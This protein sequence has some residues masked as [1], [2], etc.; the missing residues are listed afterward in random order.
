MPGSV[1]SPVRARPPEASV[2]LAHPVAIV[3]SGTAGTADVGDVVGSEV[4]GRTRRVARGDAGRHVGPTGITEMRSRPR[5]LL[6]DL[7]VHDV[8]AAGIRSHLLRRHA[9]VDGE[10]EVHGVQHHDQESDEGKQRQFSQHGT[11]PPP[12]GR[13]LEHR[14][15]EPTSAGG[16]AFGQGTRAATPPA[17]TRWALD[18]VTSAT[19]RMTT[20]P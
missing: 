20:G 10:R 18:Y 14:P 6:V 3:R 19:S 9:G 8:E 11:G 7:A 1:R 15:P 2:T 5:A 16:R 4:P 12:H 17:R 13:F